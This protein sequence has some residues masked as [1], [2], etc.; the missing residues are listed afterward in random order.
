MGDSS[1]KRINISTPARLHLGFIDLHG[2]VGRKFGSVG[3]ALDAPRLELEIT[4]SAEL[5][6]Q[7][8][9]SARI[10][11]LVALFDK[12][13]RVESH[14]S[15]RI[16]Q[17]I[18]AHNGLGSGTQTALAVGRGLAKW[19]NLETSDAEIAQCLRRG[20]RSGIG[21]YAFAHG[22]VLVDAGVKDDNLPTLIFHRPF[23]KAWRILLIMVKGQ[24]GLHGASEHQAFGQLPQFSKSC[25]AALSRTVMMKLM[26]SV[27]EQDF[28][29]F[30]QAVNKLQNTMK[31]YFSSVQE[32]KTSVLISEKLLEYLNKQGIKGTGQTSWGPTTFAI[33]ESQAQA[34]ALKALLIDYVQSRCQVASTV[35][36]DNELMDFLV[37]G[38]D[39]RGAVVVSD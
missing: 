11:Q 35:L 10:A 6:V 23:P 18:P 30:S 9:D 16:R 26:P 1:D 32:Q 38:G 17:T 15:I 25:A 39:N 20:R 28:A 29:A 27:I 21:I 12:C 5:D 19:H 24:N 37:V 22:G 36:E 33:V 14:C 3:I 4:S 13:Y 31:N 2:G 7:G 8:A 34:E